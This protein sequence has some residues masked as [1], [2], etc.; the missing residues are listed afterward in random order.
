VGIDIEGMIIVQPFFWGAER[1]PSET[2][3]DGAV[4]LPAHRVD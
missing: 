4:V 3:W 2:V 1:L